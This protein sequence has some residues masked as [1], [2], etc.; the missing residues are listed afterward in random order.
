MRLC[1]YDLKCE[2]KF[3]GLKK[4][5]FQSGMMLFRGISR[6][7][8]AVQAPGHSQVVDIFFRENSKHRIVAVLIAKPD[9]SGSAFEGGLFFF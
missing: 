5:I 9:T 6:T 3:G 8:E 2:G 1:L 4:S 7:G